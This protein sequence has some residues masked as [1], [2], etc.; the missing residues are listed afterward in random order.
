MKAGN[1][2]RRRRR[3]ESI[4]QYL[5]GEKRNES[6]KKTKMKELGKQ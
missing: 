2:E 5:S 4:G 6:S 1:I 3:N